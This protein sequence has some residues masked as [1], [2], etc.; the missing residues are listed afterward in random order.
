LL[1]LQ[2]YGIKI[3]IIAEMET[4]AKMDQIKNPVK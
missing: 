1:V 3:A 4:K 2:D